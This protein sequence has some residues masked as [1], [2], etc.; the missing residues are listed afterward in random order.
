MNIEDIYRGGD[1][2][3]SP[4]R[5]NLADRSDD[6]I[7]HACRKSY[8]RVRLAMF[9]GYG[10]FA[11]GFLFTALEGHRSHRV[12]SVFISAIRGSRYS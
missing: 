6:N 3:A 11:L 5:R 9:I 12:E 1:E 7:F 4:L 2:H 8:E 10:F